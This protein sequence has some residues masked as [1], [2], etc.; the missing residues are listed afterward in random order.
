MGRIFKPQPHAQATNFNLRGNISENANMP[1][2][3]PNTRRQAA[4][5][6][7]ALN[8][9]HYRPDAEQTGVRHL[10]DRA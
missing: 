10:N 3:E 7:D 2:V 6:T 1:A 9:S 8:Q 4:V 5:L